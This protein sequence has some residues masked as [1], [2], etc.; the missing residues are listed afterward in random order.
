MRNPVQSIRPGTIV[1]EGTRDHED[2]IDAFASEIERLA[3]AGNSV[4]EEARDWQDAG[5]YNG[6]TP[7]EMAVHLVDELHD[8]LD[9][10]APD[11][12]YFG[13]QRLGS[14]RFGWYPCQDK[15]KQVRLDVAVDAQVRLDAYGQ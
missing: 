9:Q 11:G 14:L 1:S 7:D 13:P 2:L 12:M 15:T 6:M 3:L 5:T 10:M 4:A 8:Q